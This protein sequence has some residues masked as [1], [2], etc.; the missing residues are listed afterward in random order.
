MKQT[1]FLENAA[2]NKNKP[3]AA[4]MAPKSFE[5]F[6]RQENIIGKNKLLRRSSRSEERR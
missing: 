2:V 6:M 5:E 3:L 4:R 1:N